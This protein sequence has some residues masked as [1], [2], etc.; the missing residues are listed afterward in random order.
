MCVASRGFVQPPHRSLT[1][2]SW[3]NQASCYCETK[4]HSITRSPPTQEAK[5]SVL[6]G[7]SAASPESFVKTQPSH[8]LLRPHPRPRP[9]LPFPQSRPTPKICWDWGRS[10]RQQEVRTPGLAGAFPAQAPLGRTP[11]LGFVPNVDALDGYSRRLG[12]KSI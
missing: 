6:K 10:L 1:P 8:R 12:P 3:G 5:E 11:G 2:R 4:N 7:S 9:P